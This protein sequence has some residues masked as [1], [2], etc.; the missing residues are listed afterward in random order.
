MGLGWGSRME[1][2]LRYYGQVDERDRVYLEFTADPVII[3]DREEFYVQIDQ[4]TIDSLRAEIKRKMTL[5]ERLE[6][7]ES[8]TQSSQ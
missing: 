1:K 6:E 7:V 8:T 4:E 2:R 5:K 3:R